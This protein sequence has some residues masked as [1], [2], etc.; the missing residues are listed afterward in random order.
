MKRRWNSNFKISLCLLALI[1]P[2]AETD[3]FFNA[4]MMRRRVI[5]CDTSTAG[6]VQHAGNIDAGVS[7]IS[8]FFGAAQTAGNLNIIS[9]GWNTATGTVSSVGDTAGNTYSLAIG[10]IRGSSSTLYIYYAKNIAASANNTITVNLSASKNGIN[11]LA[12][13]YKGLDTASP[14]QVAASG[15]GSV[16]S[17]AM[18]TANL[19]T[20]QACSL[21]FSAG[22]TAWSLAANGT[23]YSSA[24]NLAGNFSQ[25]RVVTSTGNYN[26]TATQDANNSDW[27]LEV[28][29]FKKNSGAVSE[30]TIRRVQ[31]NSYDTSDTTISTAFTSPQTAGNLIIAQVGFDH[32]TATVTS[33][34]DTRGNTYTLASGPIRGTGTTQY[35]YY[36]KNIVAATAGQ[37]IV[38][39]NISGSAV[40]LHLNI[41]E[42]KGLDPVS[43]VDQIASATGFST[44]ISG[45]AVT[46]TYANELILGF[47]MT[48]NGGAA[49][50]SMASGYKHVVTGGNIPSVSVIE[51]VVSSTGT[52]TPS[53]TIDTITQ[54]VGHTISF[55]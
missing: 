45:G 52:Y 38:T 11:F 55:H 30:T 10:P 26:A 54:W 46:T 34:S 4:L 53:T 13:E 15:S 42:Y 18:S 19:T 22:Y 2:M 49:T 48:L 23:N 14:F 41:M 51:K 31:S 29:A 39:A 50:V 9:I 1:F 16:S 36:A 17:T 12:H 43:P 24:I 33:I 35:I 40:R 5:T 6:L 21:L 8:A 7:S 27:V 20:T 32:S 44:T 25:H 37:N 3:A 28:A 47:Q